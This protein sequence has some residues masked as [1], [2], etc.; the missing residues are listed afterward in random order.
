MAQRR[1]KADR[2]QDANVYSFPEATSVSDGSSE[3][4][5]LVYRAADMFRDVEE[6]ARETE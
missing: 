4:L 6:R 2:F 1:L 5:E 3:A